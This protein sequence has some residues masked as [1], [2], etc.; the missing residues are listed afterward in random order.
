M[1]HNNSKKFEC[2]FSGI[3]ILESNAVMLKNLSVLLWE[4]GQHTEKVNLI[5]EVQM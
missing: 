5:L 4:Y 3:D 1:E 2:T